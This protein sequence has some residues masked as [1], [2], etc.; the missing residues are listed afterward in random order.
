MSSQ[1]DAKDKQRYVEKLIPNVC[2]NCLHYRSVIDT[3]KGVYGGE[4][5]SEKNRRCAIG[6]FSVKKTA[7]CEL[8]SFDHSK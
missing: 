3:H 1:S 7:T 6:G 4:W 8:F 2:S 5:K